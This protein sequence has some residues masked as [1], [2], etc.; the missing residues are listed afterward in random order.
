MWVPQPVS[1]QLKISGIGAGGLR[2][3]LLVK[4]KKAE[5]TQDNS[6]DLSSV[7]SL[8]AFHC[9]PFT[10]SLVLSFTC[11]SRSI[12][13]SQRPIMEPLE[14]DLVIDVEQVLILILI[15]VWC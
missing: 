7:S 12:V 10:R 6:S 5:T 1:Q 15:L 2:F 14:M 11:T 13:L 9:L 8:P 4:T 3:G